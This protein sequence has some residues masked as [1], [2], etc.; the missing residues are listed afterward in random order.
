VDVIAIG[1]GATAA[2]WAAGYLCRLPAV[3]APAWLLFAIFV[4]CIFAGGYAAGA[5]A[6]RGI[7]GGAACGAV[8]ALFNLLIIGSLISDADTSGLAPSALIWIP[9]SILAGAAIA[10]IGATAASRKA[11]TAAQRDARSWT[12]AFAKA[13]AGATFLLITMGGAV[14][15]ADAGLAVPDWPSSFAYNM[16][17][18][19][20]SRMTGG[21]YFEHAH[22]LAGM[23]VGLGSIVLFALVLIY[24]RRVW[25]KWLSLATFLLISAQGLLGG[26]RVIEGME[27]G[28]AAKSAAERADVWMALGHGILGQLIFGLVVALAVFLSDAWL[29]QGL[30]TAARSARADRAITGWLIPLVILQIAFGAVLRHVAGGLHIHITVAVIVAVVAVMAGVRAWGIYKDSPILQKSG[31]ALAHTLGLQLL[32]GIAALIFTA[33]IPGSAFIDGGRIIVPTIHQAVGALLLA[34]SVNLAL[35]TRRLLADPS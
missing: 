35:W 6:G 16:F 13:L 15:S 7:W 32:L 19:P 31:L 4:V 24:E 10:A 17:L 1:F 14:T 30:K 27:P 33:D 8:T 2:M 21:I 26:L 20:L 3:M 12:G 34:L 5:C 9:G 29:N 11:R 28:A 25:I 22:R 23:L 18:F